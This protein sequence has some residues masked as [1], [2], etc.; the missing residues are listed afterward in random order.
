MTI[1]PEGDVTGLTK[2]GEEVT[3]TLEYTPAGLVKKRTVR[4]KYVKKG[5]QGVLIAALPGRPI[6]KCIAEA[7]LLAHVLVSKY[8]DHLPFYRQIQMFKRDFGWEPALSTMGDWMAG[9][10]RLLEPLYDILKQKI[11][12]SG[13]IQA[14]ESPIKVLDPDKKGGTHQGYQWVYHDPVGRPVL[15]NY[16][17]GR[18]QHG[19]KELLAPY[20]GYLQC[21][22]YTIYDKI[23][24]ASNITLAGCPVHARR[25]F[26]DVLDNERARAESV[27]AIFR[28]IYREERKIRE[29]AKGDA[30]RTKRAL[31]TEMSTQGNGLPV[32]WKNCPTITYKN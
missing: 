24:T 23:G 22:G 32:P 2:I 8:V 17:K 16:R 31:R 13:Y 20:S 21:D 18:G 7:C 19:P 12:D 11:L 9:C 14:D 15:F 26:H 29:T 10:C 4:P 3:E 6:E 25:K 30:E 27:L 28:N 1:E 5:N